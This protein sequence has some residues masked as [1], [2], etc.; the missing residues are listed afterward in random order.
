MGDDLAWGMIWHG[1]PAPWPSLEVRIRRKYIDL[2]VWSCDYVFGSLAWLVPVTHLHGARKKQHQLQHFMGRSVFFFWQG[3]RLILVV[4]KL[5]A[6]WFKEML[7]NRPLN[8]EPLGMQIVKIPAQSSLITTDLQEKR[9]TAPYH[10]GF[11][12]GRED[13]TPG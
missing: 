13:G 9:P 4:N 8:F 10:C 2:R 5:R 12:R 1:T 7:W 6:M 11:L 3:L